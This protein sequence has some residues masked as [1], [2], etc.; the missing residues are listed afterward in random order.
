MR[1]LVLAGAVAFGVMCLVAVGI[2]LRGRPRVKDAAMT[3]S[4]EELFG[5]DAADLESA[6][7]AVEAEGVELRRR[8]VG[9]RLQQLRS[10]RVPLRRIAAS[11]GPEVARLGF[12]DGTVLLARSSA[13]GDLARVARLHH[14]GGLVIDGYADHPLGVAITFVSPARRAR[15]RLVVLDLDQSD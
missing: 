3:V 12:A 10:H 7:A 14:L 8:L 5:E 13:A 4:E 2:L 1:W 15:C 11:P 6:F 9:Q